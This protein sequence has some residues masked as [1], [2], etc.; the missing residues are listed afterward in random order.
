MIDRSHFQQIFL[1]VLGLLALGV[2]YVIVEPFIG[3]IVAA[4]ALAILFYPLF[5]ALR[6]RMT[7]HRRRSSS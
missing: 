1:I 7:R 4:G 5:A 3:P 2:C 6:R